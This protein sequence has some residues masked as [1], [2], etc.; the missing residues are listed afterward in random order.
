MRRLV[1][2]DRHLSCPERTQGGD[3]PGPARH[4][5]QP[6]TRPVV[7]WTGPVLL[8]RAAYLKKMARASEGWA[9]ETIRESPGH[10]AM[11]V[12]RLRNSDAEMLEGVAQM[13]FVLEGR[14]TMITGGVIEKPRQSGP[15]QTSGI[16]IQ[17]GSHQELRPG[18][19]V[20]IAGGVPCRCSE[21]EK[22]P[23]AIW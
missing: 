9:E 19:V 21:P 10:R 8:E 22:S 23:L 4:R 1:S 5:N 13:F 20:H 12:V 11:L 17:G 6:E 3:D 16:A 15:G 18:D 14:A 7:H 2:R